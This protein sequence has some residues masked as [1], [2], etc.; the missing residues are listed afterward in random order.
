M[1]TSRLQSLRQTLTVK[2]PG[3]I[4]E[5]AREH[6]IKVARKGITQIKMEQ[7][8]RAGGISPNV[9]TYA[10]NP[11]NANIDSVKLPGP[12]VAN[13]DYRTEIALFT[14]STLEKLSPIQSGAYVQAHLIWVNGAPVDMLPSELKLNDQVMLANPL[15]YSRRLE[16]GKTKSGRDFVLQVQPRIYERALRVVRGV[17]GN[18]AV[19]LKY[20]FVELPGAYNVSGAMAR[21][22][23][24]YTTTE[25]HLGSPG[26]RRTVRRK[27]HA[28]TGPLRVPAIIINAIFR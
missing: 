19:D 11:N 28:R 14:Q 10:N 20:T 5:A 27:R 26:G 16:I 21:R 18:T 8:A 13:F 9:R 23:P 15:P 4:N 2:W 1:A 6:L 17:Y 22:T 25:A 3:E 12:I 24:Y 7:T